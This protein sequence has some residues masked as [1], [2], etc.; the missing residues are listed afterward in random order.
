[1]SPWVPSVEFG[2][3]TTCIEVAA[4]GSPPL[5]FDLGSGVVPAAEAALARGD[6]KFTVFMTHLHADHLCGAVAFAP[7]FRRSCAVHLSGV[8]PRL[9]PA[10]RALLSPPYF[11]LRFETLAGQTTFSRLP[12]RGSM[13]LRAHGVRLW[14]GPLN[15]PQGC[16]GYRIDDGVNAIVFATDVELGNEAK[17]KDFYRLM[18]EPYPCGLAIIDGFFDDREMDFNRNWGHSSWREACA[19]GERSGAGQVVVTHHHPKRNDADL[20]RLE[21]CATCGAVWARDGQTWV[22]RQ[23]RARTHQ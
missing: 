13:A 2:I 20:A 11:P 6:R 15:H 14:W 12:V 1:M 4:A 3:H 17:D 8:A 9:R 10:L 16:S 22:L 5:F 7:L 19:A 18:S 21:R 23:N